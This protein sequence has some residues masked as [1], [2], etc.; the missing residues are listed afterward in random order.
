MEK[1]VSNNEIKSVTIK[2][3]KDINR[4][5][6][7]N[8]QSTYSLI[9]N[10]RL[11]ETIIIKAIQ[12]NTAGFAKINN[13]YLYGEVSISRTAR[14]FPSIFVF[15]IFII[16]SAFL[17]ALYWKNNLNLFNELKNTNILKKFSKNFFYI[18]ILS[19]IFLALHA[20]FLGVDFD[21]KIF[22]KIRRLI[23]ILFILF[24]LFAQ[25]F[26]TIS[27]FKFREK[28]RNFIRPLF[29]K[30]KIIFVIIVCLVT[31][32]S[33]IILIVADPSTAFKHTLEWNYFSFLLLYYLL[34]R[35]LWK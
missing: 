6:I 30:L 26:L 34:S 23:I 4:K 16:L 7:K 9:N 19:C 31:F 25:I 3:D 5:C 1:L 27:L 10:S 17:L 29:L 35:M 12:K 24:E 21:S 14:Y 18:G 15:K 8:Y 33:L 2:S 20:A 11:L 28:L 13:P 32:V 22:T